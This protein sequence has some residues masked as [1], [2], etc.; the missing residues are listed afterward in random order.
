MLL[1]WLKRALQ[2]G[3]KN[4]E[5]VVQTLIDNNKGIINSMKTGITNAIAEGINSV[6]QMAKSSARGFRNIENFKAMIF[7]L[8]NDFKFK[9][10]A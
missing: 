2:T 3:I 5:N 6:V 10:H 9:F 4:L 7:A 1:A 8:G